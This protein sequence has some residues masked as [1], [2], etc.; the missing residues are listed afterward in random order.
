M[1]ELLLPFDT[2]SQ[3]STRGVEV[4]IL[5]ERA[6]PGHV[7]IIHA[8]NAEMALRIAEAKGLS[9]QSR[10]IDPDWLEVTFS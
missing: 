9:V 10:D 8:S 3:E 5:W 6:E 7:R 4:G 1:S 2:D